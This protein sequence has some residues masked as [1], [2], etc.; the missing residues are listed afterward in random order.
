VVD[1]KYRTF[2]KHWRCCN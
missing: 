2:R 1:W